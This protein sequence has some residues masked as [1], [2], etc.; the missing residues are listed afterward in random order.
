[1]IRNKEFRAET[2][3]RHVMEIQRGVLGEDNL[4]ILT[5]T[6]LGYRFQKWSRLNSLG[7]AMDC[8]NMDEEIF[9]RD[10]IFFTAPG[11]AHRAVPECQRP[12]GLGASGSTRQS[13][14]VFPNLRRV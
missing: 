10:H 1:M 11:L 2:L 3:F 9:C 14:Q 7:A 12:F 13:S 8:Q 5:P 6:Y 4:M